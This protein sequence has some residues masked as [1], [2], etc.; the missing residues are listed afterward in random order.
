VAVAAVAFACLVLRYVATKKER[1]RQQG[2]RS[3]FL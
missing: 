1:L 3:Q 2:R